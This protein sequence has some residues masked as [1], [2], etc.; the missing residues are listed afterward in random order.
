MR[1]CAVAVLCLVVVAQSPHSSAQNFSVL[2]NFCSQ[3]SCPDG[4]VPQGTLIQG[5]DGDFYGTTSSGGTNHFGTV[6]KMTPVG[7]LTTLYSFCP[8]P[9]QSCPDGMNPWAG[10]VQANDG[11]F[12][13]TTL[14][15]GLS[16]AGTVFRITPDG[17][18]TT[19]H[20]FNGIDGFEPQSALIQATDGYL[21]GTTSSGYQ[22]GTVFKINLQGELTLLHSFCTNGC[23]D[24]AYPQGPLIQATDGNLYGTTGGGGIHQQG[25]VFKITPQGAF[26]SVYSFCAQQNCPDGAGPIGGLVQATDG[27]FYATTNLGGANNYGTVFKL[28]PQGM[29]SSLHSFNRTDG[30][31][32]YAGLIQ[33]TDGNFYGTTYQGGTGCLFYFCGT[34]FKITPGG[35]LTT[36]HS[37]DNSDG[38]LIYSGLLQA[39]DASFYGTALNGGTNNAGTVFNLVVFAALSVGKSGMGTISSGD[40]K[41]YCGTMCSHLYDIGDELTLSAVPAPGYTF[42]GWTG[43][44]NMNGSYCSV[45]MTAAK[46]VTATFAT[47]NVTLTS[48]TFK[49]SYVRGGQVSAGTLTLNAPAPSGGVTVALSS[50]HPGV[51]HPPSFVFVP[52]GQ[53]S[54][55][56]AVRTFPVKSN[57]TVMIAATAGNSHV[58]GTLTVGT[59]FVTPSLR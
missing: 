29:L 8:H 15:G 49:P 35:T 16:S 3:M 24:G 45:T 23:S 7:V 44:D 51:A 32:P 14:A 20:S 9:E 13:G 5:T 19:I 55:G 31:N 34:I 25:T 46:N 59:A 38:E 39:K 43:C 57:T 47:A 33:A 37:F 10:L 1:R 26:T 2:Y 17:T 27:N 58:S 50:D 18:L 12:Y 53:T 6:F 21:Y 30:Q 40:G 54:V 22:R 41:I 11:N 42:I 28:T 4:D 48:L 52:G 56:F 36:L